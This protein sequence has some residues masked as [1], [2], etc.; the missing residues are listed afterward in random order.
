MSYVKIAKNQ[1]LRAVN[2]I[3]DMPPRHAKAQTV[4]IACPV[5]RIEQFWRDP[6]QLSVVLGDIAEVDADGRDRYRWRLSAEPDVAW[7]STLVA[8]GD[9]VRFVGNGNQIAVHY[10][11]APHELGTEVTLCLK[12]PAPTLLSGAAAFKILYRLRALM[13]TGEVPTI[14]SNP[15]ARKSAR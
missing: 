7:D 3:I 5:E 6:D 14:Q 8:E 12:T 13:Q 2:K 15:S 10:R 4:T 9:G 11:P 1:V